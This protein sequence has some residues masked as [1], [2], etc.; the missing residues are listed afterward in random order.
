MATPL[1]LRQLTNS[2]DTTKNA[3]L[4]NSEVDGN[5]IALDSNKVD[6][7][8][9]T[10]T[11]DLTVTGLV[12]SNHAASTSV[13]ITTVSTAPTQIDSFSTSLYRSA[14]YFVQISSGSL[15]QV[16]ELGV[17]HDGTTAYFVE[18]GEIRTGTSLGTFTHGISTGSVRLYFTPV[19]ASTTIK[20][21][22]TAIYL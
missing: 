1:T 21:F 3:P 2:G 15:Y 17:L 12:A 16:A 18:Y 13:S 19:N 14:K 4:T 7:G 6:K 11:G 8:G 10:I 22:R 20:L 9:D 5:F